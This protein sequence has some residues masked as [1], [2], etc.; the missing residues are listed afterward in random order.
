LSHELLAVGHRVVIAEIWPPDE[1]ELIGVFVALPKGYQ[2]LS[3][4][5]ALMRGA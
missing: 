1:P 2:L 3:G 5:A 4:F